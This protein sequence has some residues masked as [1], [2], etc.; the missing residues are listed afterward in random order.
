MEKQHQR[1]E[2]PD[3]GAFAR[4]VFENLLKK[5][6]SEVTEKRNKL[7]ADVEELDTYKERLE[8]EVGEMERVRVQ[9]GK[10]VRLNVGGQHFDVSLSTLT[11]KYP[12]SMLGA[13]FSGRYD[14]VT[15]PADNRV[16]IDRDPDTFAQILSFLR[17]GDQWVKPLDP[18]MLERLRVEFEFFQ[19]PFPGLMTTTQL[20]KYSPPV[21]FEEEEEGG[22]GGLFGGD[23]DDA[24]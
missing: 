6:A 22:M 11:E 5:F 17:V 16:F 2:V 9:W 1:R 23:D 7:L 3:K 18:W 21:P 4:P 19:L 8:K 10:L 14:V 20:V 12:A 24:Y 15:D 13:M